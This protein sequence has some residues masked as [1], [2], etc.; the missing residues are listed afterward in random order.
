M[1]GR[2]EVKVQGEWKTVCDEGWDDIDATTVCRML[3]DFP[4]DR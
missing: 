3:T 4:I 1:E 2:V